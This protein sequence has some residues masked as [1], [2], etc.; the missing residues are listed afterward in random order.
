M[1]V[2]MPPEDPAGDPEAPAGLAGTVLRGAGLAGGGYVLAQALNLVVY[3]VLSRLL[4][5]E[6][7]GQYAAATVLVGFGVLITESGLQ[8]AVVQRQDRLP[9]AQSTAFVAIVVGG[10]LATGL[11]IATAPLLGA[12][13]DS[14]QVTELAIASAALMFV[15]VL[16]V[17]PNAILQ[18]RFSFLRLVAV[19]PVEVLAF[20]TAAIIAASNDMGPWSLVIGQYAGLATSTALTWAFA[21]WR[22]RAGEVSFAMWRELADYGRHVFIATGII[23]LGEQSADTLIVGKT[24]GTAALGQFRYAFRIAALP[25]QV[26][27]AGA[28]YVVFPA[29]SR[30]QADRERL[31]AAFLRSLRWL[32]TLG[33]PAGLI[34]V[35]LGPGVAAL[36]FGDVWLA[37]GYAAAAMCGYAGANAVVIAVGET[38]KAIGDPRPL[39]GIYGLSTITTIVAMIILAQISLTAAAASLSLGAVVGA[40]AALRAAGRTT[41]IGL[42]AMLAQIWPPVVAAL[43]MVALVAPLDRLVLEPHTHSTLVGLGLLATEGLLCVAIYVVALTWLAPGTVRE[44]TSE[45]RG[46]L[47]PGHA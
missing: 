16:P 21:R 39:P 13:F 29:L 17:V 24:L 1:T 5:P 40:I 6:D 35:P 45:L 33:I 27:L 32:A 12:I 28:G 36:V 2:P 23:R 42:R 38:L 31:E 3:I 30:L 4:L 8:A 9:E 22:P 10:L 18:R 26:L 20:G 43:V 41:R 14:D 11:G 34:L 15:N 47:R 25:Y 7:F 37:A 46:R 19:D 44:I